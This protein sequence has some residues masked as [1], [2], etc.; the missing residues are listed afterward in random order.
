MNRSP[1][2]ILQQYWGYPE[3]R[4][5][6]E[7]IVAD[8]LA[9]KDCLALLPTGG[10]K[11]V[12]YQVPALVKGDLCIVISPLIALME[13][14]A[15]Q[16]RARNI[17]CEVIHSGMP[18][19]QL[20]TALDRCLVGDVRFLFCSP[21]RIHTE[22]F[23]VRSARM[24]ISM[25]AVDEAHCIS[26]WG[27]DFRPMYRAIGRIRELHPQ[28]PVLALTASA[29]AQVQRDIV[30]QL[31]LREPAIH[32]KSFARPNISFVV[33]LTEDKEHRMHDALK[34]VNGPAIVYVRNRKA[35]QETAR[36]LQETGVTATYYHG[37]LAFADRTVRQ[38]DW[39]TGKIR[40][41]VATNAFGMGIDKP[42]VRLVI[43]LGLPETPE[44]YYQEAGRAGRDGKPSFA[45]LLVHP[46]DGDDLMK[47]TESGHPDVPYLRHIY[48]CLANHM[49]L[50]EGAGEFA[51]FPFDIDA[52]SQRFALR[53]GEVRTAVRRLEE[54]GLIQLDDRFHRPTQIRLR[55]P[56][57]QIYAFR[58]AHQRFD[59]ILLALLRLYGAGLFSGYTTVS[60]SVIASGIGSNAGEVRR[61]LRDLH[62]LGVLTYVES[63]DQPRIT[64]LTGRYDAAR[65][66]IDRKKLIERKKSALEKTSAVIR[67]A[68]DRTTCRQGTLLTYFG[69][70]KTPD[71]GCCDVCRERLKG[72]R[73]DETLRDTVIRL[74]SAQPLTVRELENLLPGTEPEERLNAIQ[75][76]VETGVL[77]YDD[78]WRLHV[79]NG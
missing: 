26:E 9:G 38:N 52:F 39:I 59:G 68:T 54:A 56:R 37:G 49:Q 1:R 60:E 10:G 8:I 50:A 6:Q 58:V 73:T 22:I 20:D 76:L 15:H 77:V 5:P 13:D 30:A 14:Q 55:Y 72:T 74:I 29:T 66:P 75:H 65:I 23:R 57:E 4:E 64:W 31:G 16:L 25:I 36:R 17:T 79:K 19:D 28:V 12:C 24:K 47:K 43:H 3:F 2:E 33:R 44:A 70:N 42:D 78:I 71:C 53:P 61:S 69:E 45:L 32:R 51:S 18:Y 41:M 11:S 35:T 40:V 46:A 63:T 21:E 67:Y 7:Q 34:R 62:E 48:Q 27:H